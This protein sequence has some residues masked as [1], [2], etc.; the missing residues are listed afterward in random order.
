MSSFSLLCFYAGRAATIAQ[1]AASTPDL[2]ILAQ[3]AQS[4][5][6]IN[7]LS[8]PAVQLTVFAPT[9]TAF[10]TALAALGL[11]AEQLLADKP[12]LTSILSCEFI[13]TYLKC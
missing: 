8:D 12:T 9:N 11:S 1:L 4:A 6:L 7:E 3:A 5:G 10:E 2:S 13:E